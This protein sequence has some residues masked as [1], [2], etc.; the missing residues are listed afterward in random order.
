M[1]QTIA[2]IQPIW[3][4]RWS[5]LGHRL[6]GVHE[7]AGSELVHGKQLSEPTWVCIRSGASGGG[8]LRRSARRARSGHRRR[9]PSVEP[10]LRAWGQT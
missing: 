4:C 1:E 6:S 8:S 2:T 9:P 3:G 7:H 5:R 10:S